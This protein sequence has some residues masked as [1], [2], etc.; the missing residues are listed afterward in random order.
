M[1]V[2]LVYVTA[3]LEYLGLLLQD[4]GQKWDQAWRT[5]VNSPPP[6]LSVSIAYVH[7]I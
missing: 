2:L 3:V 6:I 7:T 1:A 5:T 4:I